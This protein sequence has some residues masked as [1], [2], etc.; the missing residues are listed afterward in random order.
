[1]K[2]TV[3]GSFAVA[4]AVKNCEPDVVA[5]YPITPSSHIAEKLS[6]FYANGELKSYITTE[7]EFTSISAIIGASAAGSRAFSTTSSQGLAL[8]HEAVFAA[9]GMRLPV[10]MVVG[11]RALSAPLNIWNDHQDSIAQRDAGWIQLYCETNQEVVDT[12]IQ[13]FKIAEATK[14]PAMVCMDGFYLTHSVESIDIPT[15]E[16][17]RKFLPPYEPEIKLDTKNPVSLGVYAFPDHY[18]EFRADLHKDLL[19]SKDKIVEVHDEFE[20]AFGRGYGGLIETYKSEDADYILISMGSVVG[21]AK[22]AV[23]RLRKKGEKVGIVRIRAFRPFPAEELA[24]VLEGKEAVGVFEKSYSMGS[25]APL[26]SEVVTSISCLEDVP[27]VSSFVG[28]LGGKDVTVED[29]EELFAK[30]KEEEIRWEWLS[31][32]SLGCVTR[33]ETEGGETA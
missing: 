29:I 6:E 33:K 28:G 24:K 31:D 4:E 10:V 13:A 21:T 20:K 19:A 14:L 22:E 3:E 30:I 15:V 17:V 18:Y 11:N 2:K 1:M 16:E 27:P 5:C 9:A 12:T 32:R 25:L 7:A 23:D 8:M 26:H